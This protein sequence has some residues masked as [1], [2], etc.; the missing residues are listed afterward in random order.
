MSTAVDGRS[1][2]S[3]IPTTN[4]G[5]R[6]SGVTTPATCSSSVPPARAPPSALASVVVA[7]APSSAAIYVV[8]ARGDAALASLGALPACAG[9]VGLHDAERRGRVVRRLTDELARRRGGRG[10]GPLLLAVDGLPSLLSA[11]AT[12]DDAAEPTPW[13]A[14]SPRGRRSASAAWRPPSGRARWRRRV[15]ASFAERWV[16]HLDDPADAATVGVRP[17]VVPAALP[18]R[19]V[20][21]SSG[22]EAQLAVL[23]PGSTNG[24]SAVDGVEPIGML[25][26]LV[27]PAALS[28][29]CRADGACELSVGID[30]LTLD[31][32]SLTVPEGEHVLV[33]GPA[34]SGRTTAL[35][36]IAAAW[37][38]VHPSGCGRR[39][40][41]AH[42]RAVAGWAT[43]DRGGG[44][45]DGRRGRR[46]RRPVGR[47]RP[48]CSSSTTP[49]ASTT[50]PTRSP[51]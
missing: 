50:T 8:D 17:A 51:R 44:G 31:T 3:T 6:W 25:P 15:L 18:G 34:R 14:S 24:A 48:A 11:L 40:R 26:T 32:A 4:A 38:D 33:L 47:R 27:H 45:V 41:R 1:A 22:L 43:T 12:H 10:G 2:S 30:F 5:G 28:V 36:R 37:R 42:R 35:V 39:G 29:S 21:A 7:A 49:S 13:C 19:V 20:V 16:L 23:D 9:V 46:P